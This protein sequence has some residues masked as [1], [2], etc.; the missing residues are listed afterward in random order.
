VSA[1]GV[2]GGD[3]RP[4]F[5]LLFVTFRTPDPTGGQGRLPLHVYDCDCDCG[6]G[7]NIILPMKVWDIGE[8]ALIDVLSQ[9]V[10]L[11]E[12]ERQVVVGPGDDAAAWR[13]DDSILLATTDTMVQG[14][15]FVTGSN[16][17]QLGWK[18]L[19]A[20]L[21][22]IAAM[23]GVPQYALVS[24]SLPGDT[25][26]DDV[27]QL[28]QGMMAM[29]DRFKVAVVG[30]NVTR[31]P[32][33]VVTLTVVGQAQAEGILTRS[34][35]VPGDL[36]AVTGYLGSSAAGLKMIGGCLEFPEEIRDHIGRAHLQ[37][38]PRIAEGAG[39]PPTCAQDC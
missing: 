39:S 14:V 27:V 11:G 30:G 2:V 31:A 15:H 12:A 7:W 38:V 1:L 10:S 28:C 20:N 23:G 22:D 34:A 29:A 4:R 3:V 16:W 32:V 9:I 5:G 33:V 36:I 37:P 35:A 24:L 13:V 21:S 8:F 19:A 18:S 17:R 6:L 26:V 25:E